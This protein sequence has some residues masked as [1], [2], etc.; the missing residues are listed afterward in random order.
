MPLIA[1]RLF[2]IRKKIDAAL[3]RSNDPGRRVTIVAVTKGRPAGIIEEAA[4][5]GL[6]DIGENRIQEALGKS[7]EVQAAVRWHMIG[8]L[9]RN[10]AA[11]AARLF[12]TIHSVDDPRLAALL[13]GTGA[14]LELFLQVNVSG[15]KSKRGVVPEQARALWQAALRTDSLQVAG[16]MTI[17]PFCEDPEQARPVFSALRQLRD[18]LDRFGDG[19][20]LAGLS[21]GMSADHLVAVEEGATHVRIG[22][23]LT[24]QE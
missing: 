17:A 5:A 19:P 4:A 8:H 6:R 15:E 24:G 18:E 1:Q 23:A 12:G 13:A 2:S 16:L 10:K 9:Q 21:M 3:A 7:R 14:P 22:S 20:P 11:K